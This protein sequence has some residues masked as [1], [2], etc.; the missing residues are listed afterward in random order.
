VE[1]YDAENLTRVLD[2]GARLIGI[3]NRDLRTFVTRLDHTLELASQVPPDCC[4]VSESG[5]RNRQDILRLAAAGVKAVLIG[6]TLM[7]AG[8]IGAELDELK[9]EQ[10]SR[11]S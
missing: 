7:R 2:S 10:F 3:N 1:L 5:I 8:D 11:G 4:L 6:E 9:G